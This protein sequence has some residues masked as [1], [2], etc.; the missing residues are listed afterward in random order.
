MGWAIRQRTGDCAS[1]FVLMLLAMRADERGE[2]TEIDA[3]YLAERACVSRATVFRCL[4]TLRDLGVFETETR[5]MRSGGR[6]VSGR[7]RLDVRIASPDMR[8]PHGSEEVA[9]GD[10][11]E[12]SL[13]SGL[14]DGQVV[15]N[16]DEGSLKSGLPT[17]CSNSYINNPPNPPSAVEPE[18]GERERDDLDLWFEQFQR[19]Y[20]F[21]ASMRVSE[22]RKAGEALSLK[23]RARALRWAAAYADDLKRRGATRPVDAARWLRERRFDDV[24]QVKAGQAKAQG[25]AAPKVFVAKG[26]RAWDAWV[27]RGHKPGLAYSRG[28]P[29]DSRTGWWFP[30]LWPPGVD[31][32]SPADEADFGVTNRG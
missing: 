21:D 15:S 7:L 24:E 28:M 10:V 31:P 17:L 18:T 16:L 20:P 3:D 29:G 30:T 8:E 19:S 4:K 6:R 23:D 12:G 26:T 2:M 1:S 32:P 9:G 13:K 5:F 25:L 22:A 14:P 27:A 11:E